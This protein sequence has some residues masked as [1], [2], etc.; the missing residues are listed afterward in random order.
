MNSQSLLWSILSPEGKTSW[1]FGTMHIRDERAYQM[2]KN[3]YPLI[4]EADAFIGEMDMNRTSEVMEQTLYDARKNFTEAAFQKLRQQLLKSFQVDIALYNHLHPLMIMSVISNQVLQAEH[5]ISLD[6]HLWDFAK[7]NGKMTLGLESYEEQFR[8]LHTIDA[9]PLYSQIKSIG[10]SPSGVRKHTS[11]G[12]NLY[13]EGKIHALYM[14]SKSSMH[15][16]RKKIIYKRNAKMADVIIRLDQ[17]YTYFITVGA[18]HL[19]GKTGI[20]SSLK[21]AGWK[22]KPAGHVLK[23]KE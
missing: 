3:L 6:E 18:G 17:G 8:I 20:L 10:K 9:I 1:L 23:S 12:L 19:S 2:S 15:D 7:Q 13:V 22:V 16:L 21:R 5:H 14:L 11:K 4:L